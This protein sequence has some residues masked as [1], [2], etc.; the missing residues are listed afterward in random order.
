MLQV[1]IPLVIQHHVSA[2]VQA[3][4]GQALECS[5][6]QQR[7]KA[8][9]LAHTAQEAFLFA[10]HANQA[11][12]LQALALRHATC[13]KRGHTAQHQVVQPLPSVQYAKQGPT[14]LDLVC[15][16]QYLAL[17]AKLGHT[18]LHQAA[19]LPLHAFCAQREL[20]ALH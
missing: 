7:A 16:I 18:A 11:R 13:A 9:L 3:P 20:T 8:V 4:M 2:A 10:L 1:H 12:T 5:R 6:L 14:A 19:F 17:C 15:P